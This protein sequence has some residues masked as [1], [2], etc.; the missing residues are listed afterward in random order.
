MCGDAMTHH[1]DKIVPAAAANE[2]D[3]VVAATHTCG[4]CG[5]APAWSGANIHP[6]R[7]KDPS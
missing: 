2:A 4:G 3:V 7:Q 1:A 5:P 6:F